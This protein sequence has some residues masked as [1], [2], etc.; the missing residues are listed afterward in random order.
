[1]CI[2]GEF[3]FFFP[4]QWKSERKQ[5]AHSQTRCVQRSSTAR[6]SKMVLVL[7]LVILWNLS[8]EYAFRI[9]VRLSSVYSD[10]LSDLHSMPELP[11]EDIF[12]HISRGI[13]V[14]VIEADLSPSY[15]AGMCHGFE[16]VFF[17]TM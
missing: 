3:F 1:M 14:V 15:V 7:Y 17:S 11:R 4:V 2:C 8:L 6:C 12:L 9:F 16:T 10:R 5:L 13:V